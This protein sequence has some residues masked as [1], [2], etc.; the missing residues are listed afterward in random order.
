MFGFTLEFY[1]TAPTRAK[2]LP[3]LFDD[4]HARMEGWGK[5]GRM[6]PFKDIYNVGCFEFLQVLVGYMV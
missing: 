3:A 2:V 6:D 5:E 4:I 1:T